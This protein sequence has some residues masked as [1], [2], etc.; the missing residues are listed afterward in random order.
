MYWVCVCGWFVFKGE[1]EKNKQTNK[2]SEGLVFNANAL[3]EEFGGKFRSILFFYFFLSIEWDTVIDTK[4]H[5]SD[6]DLEP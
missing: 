3:V 6:L 5:W 2:S 1:R 4:I